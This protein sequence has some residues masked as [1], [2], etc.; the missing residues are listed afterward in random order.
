MSI[1]P[2]VHEQGFMMP[3]H[4]D[5]AGQDLASIVLSEDISTVPPR[6]EVNFRFRTLDKARGRVAGRENYCIGRGCHVRPV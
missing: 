1:W 6:V 5:K 3:A 2:V 4:E